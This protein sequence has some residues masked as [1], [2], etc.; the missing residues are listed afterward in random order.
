MDSRLFLKKTFSF[1]NRQAKRGSSTAAA[2]GPNPS[3]TSSLE[4]HPNFRAFFRRLVSEGM[5]TGV[6]DKLLLM[7]DALRKQA[8]NHAASA[9]AATAAAVREKRRAE[10]TAAAAS[11]L[12]DE[13]PG[14]IVLGDDMARIV[15]IES[16][17]SCKK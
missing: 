17:I 6:E 12:A 1:L 7:R 15:H 14:Q 11:S 10:G 5:T 4:T 3:S 16:L 9:A 2:N 8:A 13:N